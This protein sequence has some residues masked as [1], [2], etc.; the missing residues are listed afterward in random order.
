MYCETWEVFG[1]FCSKNTKVSSSNTNRQFNHFINL[2]IINLF[3]VCFFN[4]QIIKGMKVFFGL[5]LFYLISFSLFCFRTNPHGHNF[6]GFFSQQCIWSLQWNHSLSFPAAIPSFCHKKHL[7]KPFFKFTLLR[8]IIYHWVPRPTQ[9]ISNYSTCL[10]FHTLLWS[11]FTFPSPS[12]FDR[13]Q[14][15]GTSASAGGEWNQNSSTKLK[16]HPV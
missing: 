15:I 3:C 14:P 12:Q 16:I 4:L 5:I 8:W 13:W 10:V 6:V 7:H 9:A 2:S 11:L 1:S